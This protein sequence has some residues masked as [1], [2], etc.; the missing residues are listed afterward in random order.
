MS[1]IE[2]IGYSGGGVLAALIAARRT[3]VRRIVTVAANLDLAVWTRTLGVDA[4][5]NSLDPAR[6]A[7]RIEAIPQYHLAGASDEAVPPSVV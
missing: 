5:R 2:L 4:M 3:D 7:D 6:E 1:A